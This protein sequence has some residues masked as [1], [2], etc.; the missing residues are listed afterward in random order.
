MN[1]SHKVSLTGAFSYTGRYISYELIA[2]NIPFQAI[3]N[4][5]QHSLFPSQN[6]PVHPLQFQ[7]ASSMIDALRKT[8][9]FINTYWIRYPANGV[10][11]DTAVQDIDFMVQC[12]KKAGVK[13][14]IHISV[15]NPS[16]DSKLSYFRGKAEAEEVG[17]IVFKCLT[18]YE[19]QVLDVAGPETFTMKEMVQLIGEACNHPKPVFSAPKW[20]T[21]TAVFIINTILRDRTITREEISALLQNR[22]V[23]HQQPLGNVFF[24][25][26]LEEEGTSLCTNYIN[27]YQRFF[28][29]ENL[30]NKSL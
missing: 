14:I 25:K 6:I 24:I 9:I 22:L 30:K 13:K 27:D 2:N 29:K 5:P 17:S 11:H 4:H 28:G 26:W 7:D 19:D 21:M 15:S 1:K 18:Q 23:S 20:I 10:T 16:K 3:T 8:D 12:A